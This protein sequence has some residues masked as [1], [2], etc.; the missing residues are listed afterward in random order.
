MLLLPLLILPALVMAACGGAQPE[1]AP[2]PT[3]AENAAR[4]TELE[5]LDK[6]Q[7]KDVAYA[8][9]GEHLAVGT[10]TA[11][12]L[13]DADSF[14]LRWSVGTP[15]EVAVMAFSPSG[16]VLAA[17]LSDGSIWL[18][19][20][21]DG[22]LTRTMLGHSGYVSDLVFS[23]DGATLASAGGDGIVQLWRA[24]DG[25][26]RHTLAASPRS[27]RDEDVGGSVWVQAIAFSP[28]GERLATASND[29]FLRIW[30]V[31]DGALLE[32][33]EG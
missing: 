16:R 4:V 14:D 7:L 30:R 26:L 13:Y 1:P 20:A 11:V 19:R 29:G 27:D 10:T 31:A 33:L 32:I 12:Y 25:A 8:P 18:L 9:D 2:T 15:E 22:A 28:D 21:Q 6:G 5:R 24:G 3:L 23:P 17:G